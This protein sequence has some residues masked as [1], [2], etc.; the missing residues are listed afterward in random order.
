MGLWK[1]IRHHY[2]LWGNRLTPLS[3]IVQLYHNG[4]WYQ[5]VSCAASPITMSPKEGNPLLPCFKSLMWPRSYEVKCIFSN[6]PLTV[7]LVAGQ[8]LVLTLFS[9]IIHSFLIRF[10]SQGKHLVYIWDRV[11]Y[12]SITFNVYL[13][14]KFSKLSVFGIIRGK[15]LNIIIN[16]VK[17]CW[18]W[19]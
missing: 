6:I 7:L 5:R 17:H 10:Q 13:M 12:N 15:E 16:G 11:K 2:E 1:V 3:T 8:K 19:L 14:F 18:K 4:T 9:I